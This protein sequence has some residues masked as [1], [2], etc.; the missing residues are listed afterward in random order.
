M[1]CPECQFEVPVDAK[2]CNECGHKIEIACPLCNKKNP[3]NSKFC[4]ECGNHLSPSVPQHPEELSFDEKLK[5]IQ[6]YLPKG[7]TKK[8]LSQ[9][10]RIEGERKQVTVMFCDMEGFTALSEKLGNEEVYSLMDQVYEIL[11]HKV[12]DYEGTV[13]EFTGDGIMALFGAP[14]AIEDA[15]QRAIR[16]SIAIHRELAKFNAIMK[17]KKEHIPPLR[18]RVGIHTGSVVVGTLGNDLRVEFKAVGDTVNIA[19]RIEELAEP[20]LTYITEETYKLTEGF[21]RVE[22]LGEKEIRGKDKPIKI[23]R[24]IAPSTRRTRFDVSAERGLTPFIGRD[25]QLE[26]ILDGFERAKAGRGQVFSILSEAGVGKSRLLYEFRKAI[27]NDDVNFFEGKCL[28]YSRGVAYHPIVDLFKSNFDIR[29]EDRDSEITIKVKKGLKTLGIDEA[30][31]LPYLL[32]LLS[33][34]DSGIEQISISSEAMKEKMIETGIR[35]PLKGSEIR[36][37][38]MAIEDIHWIDKSSEDV[39]KALIERISGAR[40]LLIFTYRPEFMPT[41]GG[42]SYHNQVNLNQLSNRESLEMA[43]HLLGT[44]DIDRDLE[45]LILEKTEGVPFFIEEF[46]ISLKDLKFIER[47]GITYHLTKYPQALT[48]PS[49][50]QDVLMARVDSSPEKSKGVLQAGSVIGREFGYM[51]IKE[52]TKLPEQELL[53]CLSILKDAELLYERGIYPQLTFIF[54]HALTRDAAYQSLLKSTRKKYH[55]EIARVLEKH[56]PKTAELQPELLGFHFTEADLADQA[57]PYWIKAGEIAMRRSANIEAIGH[58]KI[59]L[60]L[61]KAPPGALTPESVKLELRLQIALGNA[62]IATRGYADPEVGKTFNRARVLCLQEDDS[63]QL[64]Q[65]LHGLAR[66]HIVRTELQKTSELGEQ[67]LRL[68]QHNQDAVLFLSAHQLL[69]TAL[70]FMGKLDSAQEQFEQGI[71][72]YDPQQHRSY[73]RL[74]DEDQGV[75]CLSYTAW[76]SWILGFPDRAVNLSHKALTLARNLSHPL[77]LVFAQSYAAIHYQCRQEPR[78]AQEQAEAAIALATEQGF[79]FWTAFAEMFLGWALFVQGQREDG[80]ELIRR[81]FA[82]WQATGAKLGGIHFRMLL[83]ETYGKTENAEAGLSVVA[84]AFNAAQTSE[85]CVWEAELYRVRGE[86]LMMKGESEIEVEKSFKQGLAIAKRQSAKSFELRSTLS[87]SRLW[88]AQGKGE[89]AR[90][91]L[92]EIYDWFTEGFDTSDLKR[93]KKLLHE[94]SRTDRSV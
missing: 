4:I 77:S 47:K 50:I 19:S 16:S 62:L 15:P 28:S 7:L 53:S 2:F 61:L 82:A 74:T 52:V 33:V 92:T 8:V 83:A 6:K 68:A 58:L 90:R 72:Y 91:M 25:R 43:S 79:V 71:A 40:V 29:G 67:L 21:F 70:W 5:K 76:N 66:F 94:L 27:S 69:G 11:I 51:L 75:I 56:F 17:Q 85:E 81:S 22:A 36:P 12:H 88:Q 84:D 26:L 59:G 37:L 38:I 3:F 31:T 57:I 48:I 1:K 42:R 39:L 32:E 18:I 9:K 45:E 24:V 93:A 60:E 14:I 10:N 89:D 13:N 20:G 87:L 54:R 34:K 64:V 41:W 55:G 49:T 23:Y 63:P 86:L 30:S 78:E 46:I 35:I 73:I 44:E 65:V 80:I